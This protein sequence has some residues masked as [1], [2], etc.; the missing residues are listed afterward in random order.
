[1]SSQAFEINDIGEVIKIKGTEAQK[2]V[3]NTPT[4]I[5]FSKPKPKPEAP[6]EE[7]PTT[8]VVGTPTSM[9]RLYNCLTGEHLY[10]TN[11]EERDSLLTSDTWKDEGQGWTAPSVSDFP[12]YR[13]LNPNTGDHHYTTDKN[14][15]D[16][17]P[18]YGWIAEGIAFF[19]ADK[20]QEENV[21][22]H[23]V[24]NPNAQG[25]GSHHYTTDKNERDSLIA[26]GWINEGTAWAGLPTE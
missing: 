1:M 22:L 5:G 19:S 16:T 18:S 13:L 21:I 20:D 15:F 6:V 9:Y 2:V 14:E 23:R 11:K 24:Y 26:Q 10:T 7:Q 4:S 3:Q 25:A 8:P 17:L 12:V